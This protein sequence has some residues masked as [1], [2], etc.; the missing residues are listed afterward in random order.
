MSEAIQEHLLEMIRDNWGLTMG[1]IQNQT[2]MQRRALRKTLDAMLAKSRLKMEG[3]RY[4]A[5]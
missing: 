4:V 5:R 2:G 3:A 1:Q